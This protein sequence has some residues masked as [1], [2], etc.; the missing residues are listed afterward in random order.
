MLGFFS[1][2]LVARKTPSAQTMRRA[3]LFVLHIQSGAFLHQK[4]QMSSDPRLTAPITA[5]IP[6]EFTAFTS[7]PFS[8]TELHGLQELFGFAVSLSAH[9]IDSSGR[10]H[11][12]CPGESRDVGI[13]ALLQSRCITVRSADTAARRNAVWPV[14]STQERSLIGMSQRRRGGTSL[15]RR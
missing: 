5:V 3:P 9:P 11:R 1:G 7:A 13:R 6:M 12:R 4:L 2:G 10:H 15:V 8:K 14:T